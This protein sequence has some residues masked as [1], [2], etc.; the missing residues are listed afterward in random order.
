[1]ALRFTSKCS[2]L[3]CDAVVA[4]TRKFAELKAGLSNDYLLATFE[5]DLTIAGADAS[6]VL[7]VGSVVQG[8]DEMGIAESGKVRPRVPLSLLA[9]T[10]YLRGSAGS[11]VRATVAQGVQRLSETI[12][13]PFSLQRAARQSETR[14]REAVVSNLTRFFY[15]LNA[16]DAAAK[17]VT[18][19]G[20]GTAVLSNYDVKIQQYYDV[21]PS[22]RTPLL[23]PDW[24]E[25]T[26][27]VPVGG[28][29]QLKL[30]LQ[31]SDILRGVTIHARNNATPL[32][33]DVITGVQ[34]VGTNGYLL[35]EDGMLDWKQ[36]VRGLEL[37]SNGSVYSLADASLVYLLMQSGGKITELYN[38]NQ[39]AKVWF[40]FDADYQGAGTEIV[41]GKSLLTRDARQQQG[42]ELWV[43]A[44][45]TDPRWADILAA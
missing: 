4:G 39:N 13:V 43:T 30:E 27:P 12:V 33:R 29:A 16:T 28:A 6:E 17:I 22:Q 42:G 5:A 37:K 23:K 24:T 9:E 11:N 26:V 25:D 41:V 10:E 21:E 7:G 20:G 38:P 1:M 34:L 2:Q 31:L 32:V 35:G 36:Y 3:V 45:D 8:Y 40:L 15:T 14:W 19:G 44:P 18:P